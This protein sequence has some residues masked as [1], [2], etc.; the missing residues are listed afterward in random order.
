MM[1]RMPARLYIVHG[2]HPCA[3]VEKALE[4][5]GVP[6]RTIEIPPPMQ[7]MVMRP[8][9]GDR[10]VPGIRFEDGEKVQYSRAICRAL[11][12]RNADP[13][14]YTGP[15]VDA[16]EEWG[17][18]AYQGI[19]RTLLWLAFQR[20]PRA[21][22]GY[23][24]GQKNPKLPMP[25]VLASAPVITRIER[26]IND[27][28]EERAQRELSE[29]PGHLDRIDGWI[30]DG[31]LDGDHPNAAD[32]QIATTTRLLHTLAD[33]RP[34]IAGRPAEEHAFRWFDRLR[35]EVPAG[36]FPREWIPAARATA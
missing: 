13:P 36:V 5:K 27:A 35:G 9:Y 32:L 6:Y 25:V 31:V 3:T 19:G 21:M 26:R 30:A 1:A 7:G 29:L 11:E 2:S 18:L 23:Q 12:R 28:T 4:L 10:T 33:V 15:E 17:D 8:L 20:C 34:L 16:A 22:Y 14:L 24:E